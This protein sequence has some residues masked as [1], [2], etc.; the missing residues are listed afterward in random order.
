MASEIFDRLL[1]RATFMPQ[2]STLH[3]LLLIICL[4]DRSTTSNYYQHE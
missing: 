4:V 2:L 1:T 3:F